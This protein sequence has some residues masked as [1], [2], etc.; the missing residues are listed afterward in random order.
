M[1]HI[2]LYDLEY[3]IEDV[4]LSYEIMKLTGEKCGF[5]GKDEVCYSENRILDLTDD[6]SDILNYLKIDVTNIFRINCKYIDFSSDDFILQDVI[7]KIMKR[8]KK[9]DVLT[10][11]ST[12]NDKKLYFYNYIFTGMLDEYHSR[13]FKYRFYFDFFEFKNK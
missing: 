2:K 12:Q 10:I 13:S 7:K 9:C 8:G 3:E 4:K 6:L 11:S 1:L 5:F